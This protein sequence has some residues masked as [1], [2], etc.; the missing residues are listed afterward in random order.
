MCRHRRSCDRSNRRRTSF[1][2]LCDLSY[3]D[4]RIT[5]S[6]S[7]DI[8]PSYCVIHSRGAG[9]KCW[10]LSSG[11]TSLDNLLDITVLVDNLE[12]ESIVSNLLPRNDWDR[13]ADTCIT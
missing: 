9:A 7:T 5:Q 13:S 4:I 3:T 11:S 6:S 8:L 10:I 12:A 2:I 1:R